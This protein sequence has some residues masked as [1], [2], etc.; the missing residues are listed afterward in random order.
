MSIVNP[1]RT[2]TGHDPLHAEV[3]VWDPL[4][5]IFHW[6][7]V[8]IFLVAW[9]SADE[10]D[11]LHEWAGYAVLG[12]I[13]FRVVWGAIGTRYARF[14]NFIYGQDTVIGYLKDVCSLRA[15]RYLGH[16]PAGGL[17]VIVL[18]V[19]LSVLSG[20][21]YMLTVDAF[22]GAE[23]LEEAHEVIANLALA[24]VGLHVLGVI[25]TSLQHGENLVRSMFTGR[26]RAQ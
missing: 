23:W 13:A 14:Y 26:K 12:L 21:G 4:V 11:R 19:M 7:L 9:L 2:E 8:M 17:M 10:W 20:S 22:R 6:S 18:L 5:R 16:N 25:F 24:L 1:A 3:K 15:K